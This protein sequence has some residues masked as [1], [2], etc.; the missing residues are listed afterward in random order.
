MTKSRD[1]I[2]GLVLVNPGPSAE[3]RVCR[4][5]VADQPPADALKLRCVG[6][7][8][9][10]VGQAHAALKDELGERVR[11]AYLEH[12]R[13]KRARQP[14][15]VVEGDSCTLPLALAAL[16]DLHSRAPVGT[17][18]CTGAM[19]ATGRVTTVSWLMPKVAR[20]L[21]WFETTGHARPKPWWILIPD[22]NAEADPEAPAWSAL[23][24]EAT[25]LGVTL[26]TVD[27]L[28][29]AAQL[30][31]GADFAQTP[32]D[33]GTNRQ[34]LH[35]LLYRTDYRRTIARAERLYGSVAQ[36]PSGAPLRGIL[37]LESLAIA[38]WA[39]GRLA[40]LDRL[41]WAGAQ[42][43][44]QTLERLL[45]AERS[46]AE[47]RSSARLAP[48]V[49]ALLHNLDASRML[50][51]PPHPLRG[52]FHVE[53]G[54]SLPGLIDGHRGERRRLL[55]TR[56]QLR[57]IAGLRARAQG[58]DTDASL[59]LD[60]AISDAKAALRAAEDPEV[61][62]VNDRA[63]V[64][65][66][67]AQALLARGVKE[68]DAEAMT[69]LQ[70]LLGLNADLASVTPPQQAPGWALRLLYLLLRGR[71]TGLIAAHW[72]AVG[73]DLKMP[74]D[75]RTLWDGMGFRRDS[76]D[77]RAEFYDGAIA[78]LVACD[79]AAA[80][81]LA[82]A[83]ELVALASDAA[84]TP[85]TLRALVRWWPLLRDRTLCQLPH[86]Q[87]LLSAL[88]SGRIARPEGPARDAFVSGLLQRLSVVDGDDALTAWR[89]LVHW[90]GVPG[91]AVAADVDA[92]A[93]VVDSASLVPSRVRISR[94]VTVAFAALAP[95]SIALDG[96]VQ[97]PA[98]DAK[99][100]RFSFD[101]HGDCVRHAT[102][103]TCEMALDAI[104]V[105]LKPD[106]LMLYLNDL[107]AD[108]VLSTWL[109]LQPAAAD[110]ASVA[111]AIRRAGR[112][113]ALGPAARDAGLCP[114]LQWALAP[115][116]ARFPALSGE[117]LGVWREVLASCCRNLDRW[118][119]LGAP[120]AD[121]SLPAPVPAG[122]ALAAMRV[123]HKAQ[124]WW[125]V[126]GDGPATLTAVY[127][128][129]MRAG[130]VVRSKADGTLDYT[131]GKASE[132][133]AGFDVPT[134][135]A[136]LRDAELRVNPAQKRHTS[137]GGGSTIGGSPR[138][139]DGSGSRLSTAEVI[140]VVSGV[141]ARDEAGDEA[142]D[143]PGDKGGD[144]D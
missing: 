3:V 138:N 65:I 4:V 30:T 15:G 114:A 78:A 72:R 101:H 135:L 142:G 46:A 129:G 113:D 20:A 37:E 35:E 16:G 5:G 81:D 96:Y 120:A 68:D 116:T 127:D 106:D 111:W 122:Y 88:T 140:R 95:H 76:A 84:T 125:L 28:A 128:R 45:D 18:V 24:R 11:P 43:D 44:A 123:L 6:D 61:V 82:L 59:W 108:T 102:L 33:I 29:K 104:Q 98:I 115:M 144:N 90:H 118:L 2:Y 51:A 87:Q 100:R 32:A 107:D 31:F 79:A 60:A 50:S 73:R 141:C 103:S 136:A 34:T 62:Q 25:S 71:K 22:D 13:P 74:D 105:G 121:G 7:V 124:S 10:L 9:T 26:V 83:T 130:V 133:V 42:V 109:L 86:L 19:E 56:S 58:N 8:A 134:L 21:D 17:I 47:R 57:M 92:G 112:R 69:L 94:G 41:P 55:G 77:E 93:G 64:C 40:P 1:A 137:W 110:S 48:D 143:D 27:N 67:V 119:Q 99:H 89:Q 70:H 14:G 139:T 36:L 49:Q 63:R 117:D 23:Q 75:P 39:V 52:L 132:F 85:P 38:R 66:Y 12:W 91:D 54:L 53:L 126:G 131:V 80:G 97:G